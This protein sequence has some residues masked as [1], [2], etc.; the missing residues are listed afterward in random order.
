MPA[1]TISGDAHDAPLANFPDDRPA[2][3]QGD[4][5]PAANSNEQKQL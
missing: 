2:D 4:D 1:F 5:R 3:Y